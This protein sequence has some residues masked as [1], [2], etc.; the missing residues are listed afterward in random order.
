M[1]NP[2][3]DS[4][5][6][7]ETL[8]ASIAK[9][10]SPFRKDRSAGGVAGMMIPQERLDALRPDDRLLISYP[11]SGNTWLRHLLGELIALGNPAVPHP[12]DLRSLIPGIHAPSLKMDNPEV[13]QFGLPFRLFKSHN[14]RQVRQYRFVY[15]VREPADTLV[16]FYH[17][18]LLER[19]NPELLKQDIDSFC[20]KAVGGWI[21]HVRLALESKRE[22]SNDVLIVSYEGLLENGMMELARIARFF[23]IESTEEN[24]ATALER[25][26]FSQLRSKEEARRGPS[27][28]YFYRKG[29]KG[30]AREEL[31]PET[32]AILA[33]EAAEIYR[34]AREAE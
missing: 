34:K 25:N 24:R 4:R 6:V 14:I 32:L 10:L 23:G 20:L 15:L 7:F 26:S 21:E 5:P 16:S 33:G 11:R 13:E 28:S 12:Q 30:S 31:K 22:R 8:T 9:L 19:S 2:V 1:K 3:R 27:D 29:K 17:Y 18:H